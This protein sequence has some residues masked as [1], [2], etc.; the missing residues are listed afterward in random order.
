ML[1]LPPESQVQNEILEKKKMCEWI[2]TFIGGRGRRYHSAWG[3]WAARITAFWVPCGQGG[4][5]PVA[6]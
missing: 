4:N 1:A 3:L 6:H 2:D 5:N